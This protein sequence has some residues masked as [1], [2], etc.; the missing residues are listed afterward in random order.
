MVFLLFRT[1]LGLSE[2]GFQLP[3]ATV[4]V[5]TKKGATGSE[6]TK[7]ADDNYGFVTFFD[8]HIDPRA[9]A[10]FQQFICIPKTAKAQSMPS[11]AVS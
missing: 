11:S 9:R 6:I 4:R 10:I 2:T 5:A 8:E 1:Q 3:T 7:C